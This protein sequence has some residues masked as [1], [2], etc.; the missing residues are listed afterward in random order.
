[1]ASLIHFIYHS[2]FTLPFMRRNEAAVADEGAITASVDLRMINF[3][4]KAA[5]SHDA[6]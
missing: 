6:R 4:A 3:L 2:P 5:L 1:V